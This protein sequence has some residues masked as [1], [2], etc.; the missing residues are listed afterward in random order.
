MANINIYNKRTWLN[1]N[2]SDST[3]SIVSFDGKVTYRNKLVDSRFLEISD[4]KT[5]IRLHQT[6]DDTTEDFIIKLKLLKSEIEQF[7]NHLENI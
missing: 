1:A 4:C 5:K 7:I 6:T 2:Y 3:S